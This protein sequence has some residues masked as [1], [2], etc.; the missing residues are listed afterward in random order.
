MNCHDLNQSNLVRLKIAVEPSMIDE[1]A[2]RLRTRHGK[3]TEP[4][5]VSTDDDVLN[6]KFE[7][8]DAEGNVIEGGISKDNS[9][10]VKYFNASFKPGLLG[11]KER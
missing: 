9:L 4:E 10:L 7:E 11:K 6:V 3:M 2:E 8:S 1:E 5:T